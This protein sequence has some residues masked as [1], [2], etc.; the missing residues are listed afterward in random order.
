MYRSLFCHSCVHVMSK[1]KGGSQILLSGAYWQDKG[2]QTQVSICDILPEHN[3]TLFS[4]GQMLGQ[5]AQRG[6][7]VFIIGGARKPA[8]HS[9]KQLDAANPALSKRLDQMICKHS[10]QP[11]P[12][13]DPEILE[14]ELQFRRVSPLASQI[15]FV[16]MGRVQQRNQL[17]GWSNLIQS[18]KE[19]VTCL[20]LNLTWPRGL[21]TFACFDAYCDGRALITSAIGNLFEQWL[22]ESKINVLKWHQV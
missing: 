12:F 9:P 2:Q 5:V 15:L 7:G 14:Q 4:T 13:G 10:C 6:S 19:T 17:L 16:C 22:G 20:S 18:K 3:K 1:M 11:W 21:L 8:R